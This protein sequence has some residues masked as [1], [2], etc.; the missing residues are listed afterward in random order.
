M[1][2]SQDNAN[3]ELLA[4]ATQHDIERMEAALKNG[5]NIDVR[6]G[7]DMNALALAA[8]HNNQ[9]NETREAS[10]KACLFLIEQGIDIHTPCYYGYRTSL[11]A[12]ASGNLEKVC[13]E[14]IKREVDVDALN[15]DGMTPLMYAAMSDHDTLCEKL[16][17]MGASVD[18]RSLK[19]KSALIEA[20]S[21]RSAKTCAML[22][23]HGAN[24]NQAGD[25]GTV[26]NMAL[27][28]EY[29]DISK[30][31]LRYGAEPVDVNPPR[32]GRIIEELR[33][34]AQ[35]VFL[36]FPGA[37]AHNMNLT[38]VLDACASGE[39]GSL[40][41]APLTNSKDPKDHAL[42]LEIYNTLPKRWQVL[43]DAH[44]VHFRKETGMSTR[45]ITLPEVGG[46]H[47]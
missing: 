12:A 4:G 38:A 15:K 10:S 8:E 30:I 41:A 28:N 14:L 36:P 47:V 34:N 18:G 2:S 19:R 45:S 21:N 43:Q 5:A 31:L 1:T 17:E 11:C 37:S 25:N 26:L 23:K 22:L 24:P 27:R 39:F 40:I 7:Q 32:V 20:V 3:L 44:Y 6:D 13:V 16:I 29:D 46:H 42:F 33:Q 9:N 35:K